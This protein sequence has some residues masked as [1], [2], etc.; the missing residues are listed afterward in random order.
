[1]S[2]KQHKKIRTVQAIDTFI[3]EQINIHEIPGL[4]LGVVK[5]GSIIYEGYFGKA[6]V[7]N[8]IPVNEHTIFPLYSITK[9]VVSTT[10]F[11]LIEQGKLSLDDTIGKY[12][13]KLPNS[14]KKVQVVHL[15]SHS[16]GLPDFSFT[17]RT[18]S[19]TAL[20]KKLFKQN[21][22]FEK[23]SQYEYNQTNF[24]ILAQLIE[25]ITGQTLESFI[26][27]NQ[28]QNDLKNTF[29]SSNF[30]DSITHRASRYY[31]VKPL[32]KYR[33]VTPNFQKRSHAANGLNTT[34]KSFI[35]WNKKLDNNTLLQ[36]ETKLNM[37]QP[38]NYTNKTATFL[39]G[40]KIYRSNNNAVSYGF[41]GGLQTGYRKFVAHHLT[42]VLLT[43]GSKDQ[44]VHNSIIEVVAGIVDDALLDKEL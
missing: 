30:G 3:E 7:E 24:W 18:L 2:K 40:W 25:K 22:S 33:K 23:G 37:W 10:I 19:N 41:T 28:F 44:P 21:I 5:N 4:A 13:P 11:Q 42:I 14:W 17:D 36:K 43:N 8:N 6:D 27:K 20:Q 26:L 38:F 12:L 16:S 32:K 9:V 15:L 39:H 29:F 34:L 35:A 1:M 31:Y